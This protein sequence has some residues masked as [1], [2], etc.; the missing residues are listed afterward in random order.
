MEF[1]MLLLRLI[2]EQN[3]RILP[4]QY[5]NKMTKRPPTTNELT[6]LTLN[7]CGRDTWNELVFT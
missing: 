4:L 3:V 5:L 1:R 6:L 2:E 7:G